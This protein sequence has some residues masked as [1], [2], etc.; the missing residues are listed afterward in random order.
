[1][2][3]FI[4]HSSK[5]KPF[6]RRLAIDLEENGIQVWFDEWELEVGDSLIDE[7]E[8]GLK[9]SDYVIAILSPNSVRS[10]WVREELKSAMTVGIHTSKT[11]ILPALYEN[12]SIPP[13]LKD[14]IYADFRQDYIIG[15][16]S[17]LRTVKSKLQPLPKDIKVKINEQ[18]PLSRDDLVTLHEMTNKGAIAL[19]SETIQHILFYS[20][21]R[22]SNFAFWYDLAK[23]YISTENL[24]ELIQKTLPFT[25][26]LFQHAL[27]VALCDDVNKAM[28]LLYRD[29]GIKSIIS[30]GHIPF[31][32]IHAYL[33]FCDLLGYLARVPTPT[34][35]Y[36]FEYDILGAWGDY[37]DF[38]L[39]YAAITREPKVLNSLFDCFLGETDQPIREQIILTLTEQ[40]TED[41]FAELFYS[42]SEEIKEQSHFRVRLIAQAN[43]LPSKV[44][45][46]LISMCLDD[47]YADIKSKA[48]ES[49][50]EYEKAL[51]AKLGFQV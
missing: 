32:S 39:R 13:F 40:L 41:E 22:R 48:H 43:I 36:I 21:S 26:E 15:L 37:K 34:V 18:Q 42:H 17:I 6:A 38:G 35:A 44:R 50:F 4:S 11:I 3:V 33:R 9:K 28:E 45:L 51:Y 27:D 16:N 1:M 49:I 14:K 24:R 31:R 7:L 20:L 29:L 8:K 23:K 46:H 19:S 25:N 12:C 47:K 10:K 5:D 2:K 30:D